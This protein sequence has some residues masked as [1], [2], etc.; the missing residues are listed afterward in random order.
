MALTTRSH[1]ISS[2]CTRERPK[3]KRTRCHQPRTWGTRNA[4]KKRFPRGCCR[5]RH[6]AERLAHLSEHGAVERGRPP[7]WWPRC[8]LRILPSIRVGLLARPRLRRR[9]CPRERGRQLH[10]SNRTGGGTELAVQK[11][12]GSRQARQRPRAPSRRP[13]FFSKAE[14]K[15]PAVH[16]TAQLGTLII[17]SPVH[18]TG[19][20]RLPE[21]QPMRRGR[22][23]RRHCDGSSPS[24]PRRRT[25]LRWR[26]S[27]RLCPPAGGTAIMLL[28]ST[29]SLVLNPA[30]FSFLVAY[31]FRPKKNI[32]LIFR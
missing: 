14:L 31:S 17:H 25:E 7:R 11:S 20:R 5:R 26:R 13:G 12:G 30:S 3:R 22:T 24:P 10:S 2:I 32:N 29:P 4:K 18:Q 9:G 19:H 1:P 16:K 23:A 8:R 6:F 15:G 27:P 21:T 28:V